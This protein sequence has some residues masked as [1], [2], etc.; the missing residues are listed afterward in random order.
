MAQQPLYTQIVSNPFSYGMPSVTM[1]S[2]DN[3]F[4]IIWFHR[5]PCPWES[6]QVTSGPLDSEMLISRCPT[7]PWGVLLH[8]PGP[9][10]GATLC[11]VVDL[12]H[13]LTLSTG[14]LLSLEIISYHKLAARL[15]TPLLWGGRCLATTRIMV[16]IRSR[17]TNPSLGEIS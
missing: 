14:A 9:K 15:G 2:A 5:C 6:L 4:A 1:G 3:F 11:Q 8:K 12:F 13:N 7:Q 16:L 10:L 17:N